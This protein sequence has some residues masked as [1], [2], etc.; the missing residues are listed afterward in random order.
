MLSAGGSGE[1]NDGTSEHKGGTREHDIW[2][3]K[4][5][6]EHSCKQASVVFLQNTCIPSAAKYI[7]YVPH[8]LA[9]DLL[10][11]GLTLLHCLHL[12]LPYRQ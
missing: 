10:V 8:Y 2:T 11:Q 6:V 12:G 7:R 5:G 1:L 4:H 3:G 9:R